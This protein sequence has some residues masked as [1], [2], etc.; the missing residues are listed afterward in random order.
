MKTALF[1]ILGVIAL[2][3]IIGV[4][5]HNRKKKA[6]PI[7]QPIFESETTHQDE[8]QDKEPVPDYLNNQEPSNVPESKPEV[9]MY[10][11]KISD[12]TGSDW[13]TTQSEP[14]QKKKVTPKKKAPAKKTTPKKPSTEKKAT[15]RKPRAK[16][17]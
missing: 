17:K 6:T 1:I 11:N 12:L 15:T 10:D 3:V 4:I 13:S 16:Q 8:I 5:Q 7:P 2:F 9:I 14:I